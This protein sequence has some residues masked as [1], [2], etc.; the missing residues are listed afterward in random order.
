MILTAEDYIMHYGTPHKS[1][2][3]PWGSGDRPYER[4]GDFLGYVNNLK[5]QGLS[6]TEI[7]KGLGINS[8]QLRA[9]KSIARNQKR[10][11]EID[12]AQRLKDKGLS[13]QAIGDRL[14]GKNESYVRGLLAPGVKDRNDVLTSTSNM[15]R[16][17]VA[18]KKYIDIG[19]GVEYQ[20]GMSATK[21]STAV[22]VLKNEGYQV[23]YVK[24]PQA[25]NPGKFT[26]IKTLTAPDVSYSELYKNRDNIQQIQDF[27]TDGGRTFLGIHQPLSI[28]SSRVGVRYKEDGGGAADGV[29]Y[30]R[31]GVKDVSIGTSRYAQVRVMVDGTHYLKGMAMY[32]DHMPKGVDLVFNTPKSDTGNKLDAFKS[33]KDDPDNPFGSTI[34]QIGEVGADGKYK[35]TSAMNIVGSPNKEGSGAEGSWD[36]WSKSLSSQFLSK[37]SPTLAKTQLDMNFEKKRNQFAEIQSLTNPTVR[38]KLMETFADDADSAAV[39]LKAAALPRQASKVILPVESLKDN[40]VYAPTFRNGERVV[41]VRH[42][43]GGTFEIPELTVNNNHPEGKRLLGHAEDAIGINP[44]VAERLSGAD[45]D[46]DTVLVIPNNS[47][48]VKT[49]PALQKLKGFDSKASYPAYDGMK[50][51][52]G[53]IWNAK[54]KSVDYGGKPP[55][56]R[57]TQTEMGK[58][59]NLI[60]DM[61]IRK[62]STDDLARAVKHS[63]VVIDAAKHHLDYRQSALDNGIA[64]LKKKYQTDTT[65]GKSGGAST[66]ISRAGS[67][68]DVR[69]RK[70]WSLDRRGSIDSHGRKV[71]TETGE[72]YVNREGKL[73]IKTEKSKKLA[74]THDAHS[75]SS[76]TPIEKV[77]ADYSNKMKELANTARLEAVRTSHQRSNPSA[78]S[79]YASELSSLKAKLNL[80]ERNRPLERQAQI[81]ANAVVRS[82][83]AANPGMS[84]TELKKIKSQAIIEARTRVGAG[85]QRIEVTDSEWHAIQAGAV[86]HKMLTDILRN[87]DMDRIKELATPKKETAL[88]AGR[89][90]RAKALL[91][92]GYT[93]AEV[94]DDLGISVSTLSRSLKKGA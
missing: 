64:A 27:S 34:R 62:A 31:P 75:L 10:Q 41:L 78:K 84:S 48:K 59:S 14:G 80:A 43:H 6:E 38:R 79:V 21:L 65:T 7:A 32:N 73:V 3:Y 91:D 85:K 19:A 55:S 93:Q 49:T 50:T 13:N 90:A 86:S 57:L 39:H 60:T 16:E 54:T 5:K 70:Q 63:M 61:T 8:T 58:I 25:T 4:D 81:L 68:V 23:R 71:H 88:G 52:D 22:A 44:H 2:R 56:S 77:Y 51:I 18:K 76:G 47:G 29:I 74:E 26:T 30:V 40:E 12:L 83:Q 36:T 87:A 28:S 42:P 20:L 82:K 33:I 24:V 89:L 69:A 53:G 17:Q 92:A 45:F 94:A 66:L 46:G 67:A 15:L 35:V 72:T 37:Q 11:A 1:G 9:A